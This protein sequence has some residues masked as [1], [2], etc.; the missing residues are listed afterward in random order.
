MINS[1]IEYSRLFDQPST[2]ERNDILYRGEAE[3]SVWMEILDKFPRCG[4]VV[5]E[6]WTLPI[7]VLDRLDRVEGARDF[8]IRFS[9]R[10]SA[11]W[12]DAHLDVTERRVVGFASLLDLNELVP[13]ELT[14]LERY[15]LRHGLIQWG[16]PAHCTEEMAVALGFCSI[17]DLFREGSRIAS[18][19]EAERPMKH[20]DWARSMLATEVVFMSGTLGAA[21]D[22]VDMTTIPDALTFATLRKLQGHLVVN[23]LIGLAFGTRYVRPKG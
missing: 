13:Y 12:K 6:N 1:A 9:V 17:Q 10:T 14:W 3:T 11:R 4:A 22:W 18:D 23:P 16:G 8:G 19:I 21:T 15:V 20:I 7:E 2:R 5:S